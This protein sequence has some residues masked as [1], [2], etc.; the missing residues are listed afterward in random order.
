MLL[1]L[2]FVIH[3]GTHSNSINKTRFQKR[4]REGKLLLLFFMTLHGGPAIVA[5]GNKS[6]NITKVLN[7][8]G[9]LVV[10]FIWEWIDGNWSQC[11]CPPTGR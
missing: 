4:E 11:I 1:D 9:G 5:S 7:N 10:C 6:I 2:C 3:F 8:G